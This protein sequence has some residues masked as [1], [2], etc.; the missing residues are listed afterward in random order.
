MQIWPVQDAK[1]RF[2]ELLDACVSE[3]PQVL[4]HQGTETAV[5]V[6][7]DE[8]RRLQAAARP[9]LKQL[10]LADSARTDSL[11]PDRGKAQRRQAVAL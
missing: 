6:P 5:L 2:S 11:V 10:L 4:T 1:A 7:I 8:W 3:G 9:S